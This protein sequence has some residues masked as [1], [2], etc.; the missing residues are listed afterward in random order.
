MKVARRDMR[1]AMG[2]EAVGVIESHGRAILAHGHRLKGL[3]IAVAQDARN[4]E[5]AMART[6]DIDVRLRAEGSAR[7]AREER[8]RTLWGRLSWLMTGR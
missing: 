4:M 2:D 1:R 8:E 5:M 6:A 7:A 3:E